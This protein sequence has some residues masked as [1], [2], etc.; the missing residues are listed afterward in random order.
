MPHSFLFMIFK[1]F[2]VIQ[3]AVYRVMPQVVWEGSN[4][5]CCGCPR[6]EQIRCQKRR[7]VHSGTG[8]EAGIA[9][10]TE[11]KGVPRLSQRQSLRVASSQNDTVALKKQGYVDS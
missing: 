5:A 1:C 11:R 8:S 2:M 3:A 4:M 9:S 7:R 10:A 6:N